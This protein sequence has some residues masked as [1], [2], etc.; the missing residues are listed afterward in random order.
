MP[1]YYNPAIFTPPAATVLTDIREVLQDN[2]WYEMRLSQARETRQDAE[3]MGIH[4]PVAFKENGKLFEAFS[5]PA[6]L[7]IPLEREPTH[8][9]GI[10]WGTAYFF[11]EEAAK[12]WLRGNPGRNRGVQHEAEHGVYSLQYHY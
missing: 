6:W 7:Y 4:G 5:T 12:Q 1:I 8:V 10:N 11:T 3:A 9:A 2:A